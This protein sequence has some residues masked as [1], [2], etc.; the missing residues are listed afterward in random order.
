VRLRRTALLITLAAVSLAACGSDDD[1]A[2]SRADT[3][4]LS[5]SLTDTGGAE[6]GS[7]E[8]S[9]A[10]DGAATLT[11]QASGLEP[12]LHGMHLHKVGVCNPD[13]AD[14]AKPE[15]KGAFLSA[16][17]HLAGTGQTHGD[18]D[19]D[20]P[21]LLVR[22][23]GSARLVVTSDRLTRESVLDADGSALIV[24]ADADN[25]GNVPSRYTPTVDETTKKT[26]DSGSRVA[27]GVLK[28]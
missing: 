27:C 7:V 10:A 19:G 22:A 28:G 6:K 13:S 20:L 11:V 24:H 21:S 8:L 17:G 23:D 18:H 12:G 3:D 2:V 16:T 25:F 14:P 5:T 4:S 9:F 1:P 26:G 15:M